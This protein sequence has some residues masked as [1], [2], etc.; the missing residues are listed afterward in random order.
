MLSSSSKGKC[1]DRGKGLQKKRKIIKMKFHKNKKSSIKNNKFK[2]FK[3]RFN[4][5]R[6]RTC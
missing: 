1:K 6:S 2:E 3:N 5:S 4:R